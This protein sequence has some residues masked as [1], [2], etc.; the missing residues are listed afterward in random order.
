[1]LN[2]WLFGNLLGVIGGMEL[3]DEGVQFGDDT[4][5]GIFCEATGA[6][7]PGRVS[8]ER[9]LV[10]WWKVSCEIVCEADVEGERELA[11]ESDGLTGGG[12]GFGW[13]GSDHHLADLESLEWQ[14]TGR[15]HFG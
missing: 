1:M 8:T 3:A 9:E 5:F 7:T 10:G 12:I 15:R 2:F 6:S 4:R 11:L 13:E 14:G